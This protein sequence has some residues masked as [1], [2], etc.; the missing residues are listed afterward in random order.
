M[1]TTRITNRRLFSETVSQLMHLNK[2]P[3]ILEYT[4]MPFSEI[5]IPSL[6]DAEYMCMG[7][8]YMGANEG[9]VVCVHLE[10]HGREDIQLGMFKTLRTNKDAWMTMGNLLTEFQWTCHEILRRMMEYKPKNRETKLINTL[11]GLCLVDM[12]E[13][14]Y[15]VGLQDYACDMTKE[16]FVAE[17][18]PNSEYMFT[19]L[20]GNGLSNLKDEYRAFFPEW[21]RGDEE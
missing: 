9:I 14:G 17:H 12:M 3:D 1:K 16:D 18:L 2:V 20:D 4:E 11:F 13:E 21:V 15:Y 19:L 6:S 10:T 8:L 5:E 7:D